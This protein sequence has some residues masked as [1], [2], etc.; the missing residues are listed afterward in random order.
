MFGRVLYWYEAFKRQPHKMVKYT[1]TIYREKLVK[2]IDRYFW[3]IH[4][5]EK[6]EEE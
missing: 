3:I 4:Y 5:T 2:L 6:K 1:Q